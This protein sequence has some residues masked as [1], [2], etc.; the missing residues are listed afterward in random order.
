MCKFITSSFETNVGDQRL[1]NILNMISELKI[2]ES[3]LV[4]NF[5]DDTSETLTLNGTVSDS[6]GEY[7]KGQVVFTSPI[8]SIK[9]V[10]KDEYIAKTRKDK[11]YEFSLNRRFGC[12]ALNNWSFV[13]EDERIF[14][15]F[16]ICKHDSFGLD[17][18]VAISGETSEVPGFK[19][20]TVLLVENV[21]SFRDSNI[22]NAILARTQAGL[23]FVLPLEQRIGFI[24]A[25]FLRDW[26]LTFAY[27]PGNNESANQGVLKF[28]NDFYEFSSRKDT[29]PKNEFH[30]TVLEVPPEYGI[31]IESKKFYSDRINSFLLIQ[32]LGRNAFYAV[33]DESA[34]QLLQYDIDGA[35]R[36][37][38]KMFKSIAAME[39]TKLN[40]KT[41]KATHR[42][43]LSDLRI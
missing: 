12:P 37:Q 17:H 28:I 40:I 32:Y 21:V 13:N 41:R 16:A 38:R 27:P 18:P 7:L 3:L 25:N 20:G 39:G 19:N 10:G 34:G 33:K 24:S 8:V 6:D 43:Q 1:R 23:D 5:L 11:E 9:C 15:D 36:E 29:F 31:G 42:V 26:H 2:D 14:A 30:R 22:E 4:E 35:D